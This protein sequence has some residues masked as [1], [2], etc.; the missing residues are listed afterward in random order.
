[1]R[2]LS[3]MKARRNHHNGIKA[4][5]MGGGTGTFM[6]LSSLKHFI[7]DISAVINMVDDGGSTGVLRDELGVLP[8]GDVRQSLVALSSSSEVM[9]ELFN[10][11]FSVG[12][13]NGHSFG[14]I[15][16]TALEKVTGNF[17]KAVVTA[18]EILHITGQVIPVTTDN[19]RLCVKK[20]NG[21]VVKGQ[22]MMIHSGFVKGEDNQFYLEP[23]G[24][25]NPLAKKAI[26]EADLIILGPGNLH[27]SLI[28]ILLA[29]GLPE[30]LKDSPGKKIYISNMM[31]QPEQTEGFKVVDFV[32]EVEKYAG[33]GVFDYVIYNNKKPQE[34]V[35]ERYAKKGECLVT[36]DK[37]DFEGKKYQVIGENI[38]SS[39]VVEPKEGDKIP[40]PLIRHDGD[41]LTRLLMK[42]Y[43]S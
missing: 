31:T 18:G 35:L 7:G 41:K 3:D 39:K 16:L 26:L 27:S 8:P 43:F 36:A 42:I 10:Y 25:L 12:T 22:K 13:F 24:T 21:H 23:K 29:E 11:R 34:E 17:A 32:N 19:V 5:V 30:A 33:E 28:P 15:F 2:L 20:E 37:K 1:M 6:L 14:N 9:R 40:R 4:V 38:L